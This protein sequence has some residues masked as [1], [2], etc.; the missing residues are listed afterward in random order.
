MAIGLVCCI[1]VFPETMSHSYLA[2]VATLLGDLKNYSEAVGAVLDLP[3]GDIA[4]DKNGFISQCA[5]KRN[6]LFAR[7]GECEFCIIVSGLLL[8]FTS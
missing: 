4:D 6:G 5:S 1:F 7:I 3:P 8:T 2:L